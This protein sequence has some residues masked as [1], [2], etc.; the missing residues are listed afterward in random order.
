MSQSTDLT[1][2]VRKQTPGK[3]NLSVNQLQLTQQTFLTLGIFQTEKL[4]NQ[5]LSSHGWRWST[6]CLPES[7]YD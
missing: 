3:A 5:M 7:L 6:S 2:E 4:S 1:K